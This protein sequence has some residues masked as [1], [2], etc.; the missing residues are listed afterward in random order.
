MSCSDA[1]FRAE[2]Y[3]TQ[4]CNFFM[5]GHCKKGAR[6]SIYYET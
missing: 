1:R 5:R 2:V 4:L 6:Q 3:K